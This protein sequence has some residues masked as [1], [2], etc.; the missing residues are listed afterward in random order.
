MGMNGLIYF[1]Y[2]KSIVQWFAKSHLLLNIENTMELC[3]RNQ[4]KA[5]MAGI[6]FQQVN[7]KGVT[8]EQVFSFI[9]T[10]YIYI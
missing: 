7:I 4:N 1:D 6:S 9:Y 3:C 2:I 10:V 8:V 5:G